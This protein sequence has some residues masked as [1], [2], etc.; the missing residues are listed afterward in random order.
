MVLE[1]FRN[2]DARPVYER[3]RERG[4]LAPEGLEYIVSWVDSE[5]QRCFQVME[6]ADP[7]LLDLW[8]QEWQDLVEFEVR[9]VIPSDEA[10]ARVL[11]GT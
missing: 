2:G 4:R 1:R 11:S 5:L 3:V 6:T 9:E 10:A 8:I 7:A